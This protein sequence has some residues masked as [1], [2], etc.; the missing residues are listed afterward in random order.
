MVVR[1][2][3]A[4]A[5]CVAATVAHAKTVYWDEGGSLNL[6][7][8]EIFEIVGRGERVEIKGVCLS[9]C[10]MYLGLDDVCVDA[11]AVLMFHG[12]YGLNGPISDQEYRAGVRF[13]A[14]YYPPQIADWFVSVGHNG[15]H[16][17]SG[18][19]MIAW[20]VPDCAAR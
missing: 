4:A 15:T 10:T 7:G 17:F 18:R 6:R 20:G 11:A 12:P 5:L 16:W 19:A 2:L 3:A 8:S 14:G 1:F 13:M 9:S